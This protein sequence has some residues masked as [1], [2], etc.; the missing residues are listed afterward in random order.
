MIAERRG[1]R[2]DGDFGVTDGRGVRAVHAGRK[3]AGLRRVR[4]VQPA[5]PVQAAGRRLTMGICVA[6]LD[7]PTMPPEKMPGLAAVGKVRPRCL[8]A[9]HKQ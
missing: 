9:S 4:T 1:A 2:G 3:R 6:I 5:Q 8:T 7:S